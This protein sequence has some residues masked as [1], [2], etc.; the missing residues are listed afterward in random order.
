MANNIIFSDWDG[1]LT[2]DEKMQPLFFEI[3]NLIKKN[4]DELVIVSG[5]SVSW[6]HFMMSHLPVSAAIMESGGVILTPDETH[7]IKEEYL[8]HLEDLVRLRAITEKLKDTFPDC[9]L[10]FDSFGRCADRAVDLLILREQCPHLEKEIYK[11]FKEEGVSYAA[12]NIHINFWFGNI[13]K[14]LGMDYFFKHYRPQVKKENCVFFGDALNDEPVFEVYPH[15]V[16]VS[17]IDKYWDQLKFKPTVKL[18]GEEGRGPRGVLSYL[19]NHFY[20]K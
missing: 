19:Q 17:N 11:F 18:Q 10:S 3:A 5:R 6:G 14:S 13:S 4:Q 16:A 15:T 12:S 2:L 9:P 8:V 20:K 1:T 7:D